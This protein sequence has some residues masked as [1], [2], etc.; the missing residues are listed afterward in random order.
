MRVFTAPIRRRRSRPSYGS[1][2][3]GPSVIGEFVLPIERIVMTR[4]HFAEGQI[5]F[6]EGDPA[7]SVLRLLSGTVDILRELD[8][9]PILLGTVGAGQFIGEMGVV[10]NRPRSATARAA[11]EVEVEILTP[12]EFL[13]Q[14]ASSPQTARELI[15][16]LSQRLREADDRIVNDERRSGQTQGNRKSAD[17]QTAVSLVNNAYLA[18]KTPWLQRQLHTPLGLGELPFVV[19]RELVAGEGLPPLQPDL[20]LGDTAPFRLSRNHFAIEKRDGSYH[21]R[22][23][24]STLGTVV[25]GEPIGTHFRTD[26]APLRAGENEVIAGGMDS[27]FVFSVFVA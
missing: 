9:D 20:K 15:R 22:D 2:G 12:N 21:V 13:D 17:D 23:L 14:I 4:V 5:L 11:S 26:D 19:G 27:S 10:E 3:A 16:R 1:G 25:N 24:C 7:D 18:A 8:G 6:T